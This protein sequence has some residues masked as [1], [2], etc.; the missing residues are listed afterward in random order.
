MSEAVMAAVRR[1]VKHTGNTLGKSLS[2]GGRKVCESLGA[3]T[4]KGKQALRK[5]V[6]NP[7]E[8]WKT[9]N[10][11]ARFGVNVLRQ[12]K[13]PV[14]V[15]IGRTGE[16]GKIRFKSKTTGEMLVRDRATGEVRRQTFELGKGPDQVPGVMQSPK[17]KIGRR[18]FAKKSW[19]LLQV[20][21]GRGGY[22]IVDGVPNI[23][24]VH[25]KNMTT[26][27]TITITNRV[28][29]MLKIIQGGNMALS[30]AMDAAAK[31]MMHQI[32]TGIRKGLKTT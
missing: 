30:S 4:P 10:R 13:P 11:R 22:I 19:K 2:W 24:D 8:R 17:R 15:P 31:G 16:F 9:D 14:W 27:P 25:L 20:R 6:E 28:V 32:D 7:D 21:M 26:D 23:G 18:G 5:V 12:D 3:R 1:D 29:Y